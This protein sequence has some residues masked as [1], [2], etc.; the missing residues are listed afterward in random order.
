MLISIEQVEVSER[1]REDLGEEE[2]LELMGSLQALGQLQPIVVDQINREQEVEFKKFKL[3]AGERRLEA[4][5]RL[6]KE[7]K[8]IRGLDLGIIKAEEAEKVSPRV[9]LMMEF[10]ENEKRKAF[11]YVEKARFIRKFHETMEGEAVLAGGVWTAELTAVSLRLSPASISHYLRVEQAIKDD[12][13]VAKAQTLDA[14]VKR[15]KVAEQMKARQIE[16]KDNAPQALAKAELLLRRGDALELIREVPDASVDLVNFDPPWGDN[17][18]HKSN[19]NWD[20]FDDDTETSDRIINGL[21]PELFRVLK[22][23]RFLIFWYRAWAYNDMCKRLESVGFNLKFT[24]TPCIWFKPDKVSDQNRFPEK[25]LHGVYE[26]FL[27]ARKGEPLLQ[28]Q[29]RP[30]VFVYDR[31][32]QAALIHPTEKPL[33]LCTELV[34]LLSTGSETLL[35][36]TAG[37]SAFLHA[38]LLE[39]RKPLGFELSESIHSRAVTRLGEVLKKMV[40]I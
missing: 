22:N 4:T 3:I 37:G 28:F 23:D 26:T 15:M 25:Q 12:P 13:S 6:H 35:D 36:P 27:M 24:R 8:S 34:K 18:G 5:K 11:T 1:I 2:I 39:G 14:A 21:L 38:A 33:S 19:E 29:G 16:V 32:P 20:G 9:Q 7:G 17:T 40:E 31:V 30:N 10:D